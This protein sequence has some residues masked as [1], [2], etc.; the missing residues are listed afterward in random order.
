LWHI[1]SKEEWKIHHDAHKVAKATQIPL[2]PGCR[3]SFDFA[4]A[5]K[6]V[7]YWR[8]WHKEFSDPTKHG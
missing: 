7:A 6:E 4:Q 8:E 3:V 1:P 5:A 2:C